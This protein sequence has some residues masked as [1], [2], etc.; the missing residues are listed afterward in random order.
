[1]TSPSTAPTP[2]PALP[3]PPQPSKKDAAHEENLRAKHLRDA[4][5]GY[6]ATLTTATAVTDAEADDDMAVPS[7]S[8]AM[9]DAALLA[10]S[11]ASTYAMP[12]DDTAQELTTL[13]TTD[14]ESVNVETV[15]QLVFAVG[16]PPASQPALIYLL[17]TVGF[18]VD[19][20]ET[21][22]GS[23]AVDV[24]WRGRPVRVVSEVS[25]APGTVALLGSYRDDIEGAAVAAAAKEDDGEATKEEVDD[26][27]EKAVAVHDH[28]RLYHV[29]MD[30]SSEAWA[31]SWETLKLVPG[32]E[33]VCVV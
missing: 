20:F 28:D 32:L 27:T 16:L 25:D 7:A 18:Q 6:I 24:K 1:M 2:A 8:A 29:E 14:L 17:L 3:S 31:W 5:R 9:A 12:D 4:L 15:Y 11:V 33:S 21:I 26:G 19:T 13:A 23:L 30:V 10:A 22:L